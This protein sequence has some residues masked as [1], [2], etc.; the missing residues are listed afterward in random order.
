MNN[1]VKTFIVTMFISFVILPFIMEFGFYDSEESTGYNDYARITEVDYKAEVVDEPG[2]GGKVII[3]EVLTYDIHAA[4]SENLFWELWRDL[5]ED[6]V[7]G[8]KVDYK[9]NYVK[10][11]NK[12]G[13]FTEYTQS[14]KLYWD[15]NDYIYEP[16]GPGKWYH[17]KGPYNEYARLYECVFFY[18]DGLYREKV[19]FEIQYEMRN[20]SLRYSDV[21]ELYLSMY[22]EETIEHLESFEGQVL[23]PDDIMPKEGNY[24]AHTYGTNS[25]T[26]EYLESDTMN[27]GYHTFYFS[28]D[29]KDLKFKNYNQYIEFSLLAFNDDKHIFTKYA[30]DNVYSNDVYLAEALT[31]IQEYDNLPIKARENKILVLIGSLVGSFLLMLFVANRNKR[32]RAKHNLYESNLNIDYFRD[33][34]SDLDP[35]FAAH[36][37]FAKHKH[38]IDTGDTYS[39]IMLNLVRKGYIRLDRIDPTRDWIANNIVINV[40]YK[41][42]PTIVDNPIQPRTLAEIITKPVTSYKSTYVPGGHT[43]LGTLNPPSQN[44]AKQ[45]ILLARIEEEQMSSNAQGSGIKDFTQ[46]T[47]QNVR[48]NNNT[49]YQHTDASGNNITEAPVK[50]DRFNKYGKKLEDLSTNEQ[51]YFNLI[52]KHCTNDSV[53]MT[54]FQRKVSLDYD[55]TDTFVTTIEKSIVNIGVSQGYFQ[56]ADYAKIKDST[57]SLG[58]KY[59]TFAI[60]MIV[61]AFFVNEY[62]RLDFAFGAPFIL[63][64]VLIICGINLKKLSLQ[65][66]LFTQFGEDEYV[67]WRAL[68]NFLNSETLLNERTVI[69]LPIWEQY[70]VYATAFGIADKVTKAIEINCPDISN[71]VVLNNSYYR[72]S[73]FRSSGR[74]FSSSARNASSVSRGYSSGGSYYGGGGRGG[75]GG[76]GGH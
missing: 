70:L 14:D 5:P 36:L 27:P 25:H 44:V 56:K 37:V 12:D 31:A 47:I 28:L 57:N 29:E 68:Y 72:S 9:V 39:A 74:S 58:N 11:L 50:V 40:L 1:V 22:S 4:S 43:V 65:Y 76:G 13:S 2:Q 3:T 24:V 59:I 73:G 62:S 52:V 8:L 61:V 19:T 34:P 16:Y 63:A 18:V 51:A 66:V 53:A 41:P 26:F 45:D 71:S 21:S 75:G 33:I 55:N 10:Q 54:T 23:F 60:I 17:S 38:K 46:P 6:T 7:D 35:H 48:I 42:L 49:T 69:E 20:A 67:K 30:P 15:D 32:I 64:A